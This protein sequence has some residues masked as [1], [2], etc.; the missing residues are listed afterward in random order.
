LASVAALG[1]ALACGLAPLTVSSAA[2]IEKTKERLSKREITGYFVAKTSRTLS[3]ETSRSGGN[4]EETLIPVNPAT[5]KLERIKSLS[6]LQPGDKLRVQCE[7]TYRK[8][9]Q[10]EERLIGMTANKVTWLSRG[11]AA[12]HGLRSEAGSTAQ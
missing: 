11:V 4:I 10:G 6:E 12:T 9:E 3:I 1:L 2:E 7:L 5:V 8:D